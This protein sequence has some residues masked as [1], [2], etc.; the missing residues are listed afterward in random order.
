MDILRFE[1][2]GMEHT[3][4]QEAKVHRRMNSVRR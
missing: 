2:N 4:E 3:S 1:W